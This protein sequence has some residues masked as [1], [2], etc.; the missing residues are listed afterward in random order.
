[1]DNINQH[2]KLVEETMKKH[3]ESVNSL[4]KAMSKMD[5]NIQKEMIPIYTDI[6]VMLD[7]LKTGNINEELI[8]KI[9]K[10]YAD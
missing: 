5:V 8:T 9:Q 10:K 6:N 4:N 2:I 1:M 3:L 7:M